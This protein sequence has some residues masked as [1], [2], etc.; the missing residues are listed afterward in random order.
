MVASGV[1]DIHNLLISAE[2]NQFVV[3]VYILMVLNH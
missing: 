3:L 2:A 1:L